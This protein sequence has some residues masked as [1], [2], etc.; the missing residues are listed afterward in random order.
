MCSWISCYVL[1]CYS[2]EIC[3]HD[4]DKRRL[5]GLR[6]STRKYSPV[7]ERQGR[8]QFGDHRSSLGPRRG[9][10]ARRRRKNELYFGRL[11]AFSLL[12]V[13]RPLL[14]GASESANGQVEM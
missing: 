4:L 9:L 10:L 2:N 1:S 14:S 5:D 7:T 3:I 11:S 12:V 8:W 13:W 6:E